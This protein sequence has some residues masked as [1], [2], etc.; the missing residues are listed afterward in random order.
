[1]ALSISAIVFISAIIVGRSAPGNCGFSRAD[2]VG[3]ARDVV[4]ALEEEPLE[5]SY[6]PLSRPWVM[7]WCGAVLELR[8]QQI[9]HEPRVSG[10]AARRV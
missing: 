6:V 7:S 5:T 8:W 10:E 1:M 4:H 3:Q 2:K 9:E